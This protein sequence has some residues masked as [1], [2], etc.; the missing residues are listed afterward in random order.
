[1]EYVNTYIICIS[2]LTDCTWLTQE[3]NELTTISTYSQHFSGTDESCTPLFLRQISVCHLLKKMEQ[4][5]P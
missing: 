5:G 4:T 2:F 3:K 1:M